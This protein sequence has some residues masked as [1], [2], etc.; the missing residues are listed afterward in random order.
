MSKKDEKRKFQDS[1]LTDPSFSDWLKKAI[2]STQFRCIVCHKTLSLST[3]GRS[4]LTDHANGD[5]HKDALSKRSNFFK[6]IGKKVLS[7]V[8]SNKDCESLL[9]ST[10]S[11]TT[12]S[13]KQMTLKSAV[14]L[15]D[16]VLAEIRWVLKAVVSGYSM[17]SL[18]DVTESFS[19]MFPDSSIASQ[20]T[21]KRTKASYIANFG[22]APHFISMLNNQIDKSP[23]YSL[24]FD[25]SL[26]KTT[27]ECEMDLLI[28]YWDEG[29]NNVKVRYLGSSFFGHSTAKDLLTQFEEITKHLD[30]KKN[31][32]I[33]MDG[34]NVNLRF[35][36]DLKKKR[37][38]NLFHTLVDIG[39]CSLHSVHGAVKSGIEKTSWNIKETLKGAFYL[40]HDSPARR[41]DFEVVT[42][43]NKYPLYFCAT[44]WV[45]NKLVADRMLE[46]WANMLKIMEFW[47]KLP[48]YKQP[49]CKSFVNLNKAVKDPLTEAKISCFSFICSL[50]EPYLKKFQSDKP[51]V[52]FLY[53]DLKALI[54]NILQLVVKPVILDKCKTGMQMSSIDLDKNENLLPLTEI[55]LGFGVKN[56]IK[57]LKRKDTITN[58]EVAEF[59]IEAQRFIISV[60][61]KLF[62][63]S[64]IK[65]DFVRF[66][67]IF[68]PAVILSCEKKV[69]QK[70][71][72]LLLNQFMSFSILSPAQCDSAVL[73]FN[74]FLDNELKKHRD[75]FE[76]FEESKNRLDD[77]YFN[78]A[79]VNCY[80]N[81]SFII[82]VVLTLSHGQASIERQFSVNHLVLD[83]NMKEESIVARKHIIDHMKSNSLMPYSIEISKD[84]YS[85]VKS[86]SHKYREYLEE[87]KK[88]KFV[89][90]KENQMLVLVNDMARLRKECDSVKR[91]IDL[92][93]KDI[94]ESMLLAE[95]KHDLA[96]VIK[97]NALKRKCDESKKD[98][99][100]LEDQYSNLEEKKRK[101]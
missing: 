48:K 69:L 33:S 79:F 11:S 37:N 5:K 94:S 90:Q 67:S 59:K 10:T 43:S 72:K 6:P 57:D 44:R 92:M 18:N 76:K 74:S 86:A 46:I 26:N 83:N 80:E 82:K 62:E 60:L 66:C 41:E 14:N 12:T 3:A 64:P 65:S 52:P 84:F 71:F 25:E 96:Y 40:L 2:D 50:V 53:T 31:Y 45:E 47:N 21:L 97:G 63:R 24:S 28:R 77:F 35:Y 101:L 42:M 91:A 98:L 38:D 17:N 30:P 99:K 75:N 88:E 20:M 100:I 15:S 78:Y 22:I 68:D 56:I 95:S 13:S 8:S 36:E 39:T 55:E 51:M 16:V 87:K 4:A 19:A 89:G 81:L 32:Q 93:E 49:S 1:W 73:E 27:Q 9:L 58:K 7:K 23:I 54:K 29:N 85:S 70:R 34:P 61:Q